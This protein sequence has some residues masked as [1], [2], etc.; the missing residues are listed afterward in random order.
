LNT[1]TIPSNITL[2]NTNG[3]GINRLAGQTITVQGPV[4]SPSKQLFFGTG[5]DSFSGNAS[6]STDYPHWW[7]AKGDGLTDNAPAVNAA[8]A[9]AKTIGAAVVKLLSGVYIMA[10]ALDA[11][12]S[13]KIILE[14]TGE[15]GI[16]KSELRFSASGSGIHVN[17]SGSDAITIQHLAITYSSASFTGDVIG[18][19]VSATTNGIKVHDCVVAGLGPLFG[20]TAVNARTLINLGNA[21]W[22][23]VTENELYYAKFGIATWGGTYSNVVKVHSNFAGAITYAVVANPINLWDISYNIFEPNSTTTYGVGQSIG[24]VVGIN[25]SGVVDGPGSGG[26]ADTI[27]VNYNWFGDDT[28]AGAVRINYFGQGLTAKGNYSNSSTVASTF[29]RLRNGP[30]NGFDI[31]GNRF[32]SNTGGIFIDNVTQKFRNF[33]DSANSLL[34]LTGTLTRYGVPGYLMPSPGCMTM[35]LTTA[36]ITT[37]AAQY[38]GEEADH[39]GVEVFDTTTNQL[40]SWNGTSFVTEATLTGTETLTN[41]SLTSPALTSPTIGGGTAITKVVVYAPSLTP[42]SVAANTSAEQDFTV[43]GLTTADTV[44]VN[45]PAPANA[46]GI[47][48]ARVK[49][50]NTLSLTFVNPTAG[51][52]TPVS[53]TYMILAIRN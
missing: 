24:V 26:A 12:S 43:S 39:K 30:G 31:T 34:P 42:A 21:V 17:L 7:G 51:A 48:N 52:L 11:S 27:S 29:I 38:V 37:L 18:E 40:K 50:A 44:T 23:T 32:L 28:V 9:A 8:W 16:L 33:C 46:T 20:G 5:T 45:G 15:R 53:G 22:A 3:S 4:I 13:H 36:Q 19:N 6:I 41:K 35:Q 25:E 1:I 49:S 10:S 47:V 14:G 2:N